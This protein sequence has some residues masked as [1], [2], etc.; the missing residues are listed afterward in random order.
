MSGD[1]AAA[2][3]G[4]SRSEARGGDSGSRS[5]E[6]ANPLPAMEE[7]DL[8]RSL[9]PVEQGSAEA[10]PVGAV[11]AAPTATP[12]SAVA[13]GPGATGLRPVRE[14]KTGQGC[15]C[16]YDLT[17][18]G[19]KCDEGSD[20]SRPGSH[21]P[22]CYADT[23]AVAPGPEC[24]APSDGAPARLRRGSVLRAEARRV[25]PGPERPP[26]LNRLAGLKTQKCPPAGMPA[27]SLSGL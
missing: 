3:D 26:V 8:R 13:A 9:D 18:S 14:P 4:R 19:Q 17:E 11:A 16:P 7:L 10:E 27:A 23:W 12:A 21:G 15:E 1:L 24:P 25:D 20:W 6:P 22:V 2:A 5:E